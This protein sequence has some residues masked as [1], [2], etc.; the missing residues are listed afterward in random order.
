H[1]LVTNTTYKGEY[2]FN[3]KHWKLKEEKPVSEQIVVPVEPII[4]AKVFDDLQASLKKRNPKVTPPRTVTGP[5]LL[6][7]LASCAS[8][9]GGMTL[10]TG[11]SGRCRYYACATCAQK[12]KEACEGRAIPMDKL[13]R[14]VTDRVVDE[15]LTPHRV[16]NLLAGLIQR[17]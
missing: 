11:K 4:D 14:I 6:T 17:Q 7:G 13:D 2:R 16:E 8:C 5:I 10:R 9:Q 1:K 12:G 15:L 3:R